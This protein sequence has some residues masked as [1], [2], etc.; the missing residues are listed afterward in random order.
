MTVQSA[1]CSATYNTNGATVDFPIPF[2]FLEN[3]HIRI[4][5][6][7]IS[8]GTELVLTLN[9]HYT[10]A[11]ADASSGGT[12]T[13]VTTYPTGYRLEITRNVPVTQLTDYVAND[14]FPAETH[15]RALDKLTMIAQEID[16]DNTSTLA[17]LAALEALITSIT[18]SLA[19]TFPATSR[20]QCFTVACSYRTGSFT[21]ATG[22]GRFRPPY[23]FTIVGVQADLGTAQTSGS[24]IKLDL[25]VA[26]VSILSTKMQIENGD[27]TS[28]LSFVAP[29]FTTTLLSGNAD[30]TWDIDQVGDGTA[31]WL[32]ATV[33]GYQT[34]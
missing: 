24:V 31:R 19:V 12:A 1:T 30:M 18:N 22:V 17:E 34:L 28:L 33:W 3:S 10:L 20:M 4:T 2:R 15:E 9:T 26:G 21:A 23:G 5:R 14:P 6:V 32:Q 8:D 13:M 29:V 27:K 25:N 7:T 16:F 11:G